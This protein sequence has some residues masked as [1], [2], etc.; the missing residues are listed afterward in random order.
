MTDTALLTAIEPALPSADRL[1]IETY[2][3]ARLRVLQGQ[4]LKPAQRERL[5]RVLG[6]A[7]QTPPPFCSPAAP[8]EE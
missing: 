4:P 7:R 3:Y 6:V 1:T 5:Q 8:E 2:Y